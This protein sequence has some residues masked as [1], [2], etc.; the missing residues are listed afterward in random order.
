MVGMAGFYLFMGADLLL[1]R[2]GD[3]RKWTASVILQWH[4]KDARG[5]EFLNS[6]NFCEGRIERQ[7]WLRPESAFIKMPFD[8]EAHFIVG[9]RDEIA[10]VTRIIVHNATV[11]FKD[12]HVPGFPRA[13]FSEGYLMR[14]GRTIRIIAHYRCEG[15]P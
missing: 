12:V 5:Q 4:G 13:A 9:N 10:N 11:N 7:Q 1:G 2:D 3:S 14:T 6:A 15:P 8:S